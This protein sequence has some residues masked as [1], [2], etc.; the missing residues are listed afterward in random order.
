MRRRVGG[1]VAAVSLSAVLILTGCSIGDIRRP[2]PDRA[3][4]STDATVP[5]GGPAVEVRPMRVPAGY[6]APF[7]A[8]DD[9]DH[10]YAFFHGC[11]ARASVG[12][13]A[14]CPSLLYA[15]ADGGRSWQHREHPDPAAAEHSM[16]VG[17]GSLVLSADAAWYRSLD[18]GVTF[19]RSARSDGSMP[20]EFASWDGPYQVCC[21]TDAVARV[22]EVTEQGMV[23]LAQ[24][25]PI[26][27]VQTVGYIGDK[28]TV[29]GLH[30]GRLHVAFGAPVATDDDGG[31]GP[32]V[33]WLW[34]T[35]AVTVADPERIRRFVVKTTRSGGY[36][37]IGEPVPLPGEFPLVMRADWGRLEPVPVHDPPP[38]VV[39]SALPDG[40]RLLLTTRTGVWAVGSDGRFEAI[41]WPVQGAYLTRLRDGTVQAVRPGGA[42][43]LKVRQPSGAGWVEIS[44]EPYGR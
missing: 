24:Q 28:L 25:P 3:A 22:V 42:V 33:R 16:L 8:F 26:P 39:V 12:V 2:P 21:Q 11:N 41:D 13:A 4:P 17:H 35:D 14:G 44:W 5:V 6:D 43:L 15:T 10:G 9:A 38:E 20:P 36:W 29:A 1:S 19:T 34:R 7:I 30:D 27:V 37:L 31:G 18:G 40:G 23:P 32:G